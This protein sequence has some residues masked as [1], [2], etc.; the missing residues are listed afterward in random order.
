MLDALKYHQRRSRCRNDVVDGIP[1]MVQYTKMIPRPLIV[2]KFFEFFSSIDV[3]DHYR[4][5]LLAI[6]RVDNS[7]MAAHNIS[8]PLWYMCC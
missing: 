5:G 7:Y 4:Q 6:E 2:E 8:D 1:T 3:H